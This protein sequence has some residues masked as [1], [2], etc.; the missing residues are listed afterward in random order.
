LRVTQAPFDVA[1]DGKGF[2]EVATPQGIRYTRQGSLHVAQDG[3]LVTTDG[4]PVLAAHPSGLSAPAPDASGRGPASTKFD[5]ASVASR[6]LNLKDRGANFSITSEG[7]IYAG[8]DLIGKLS[9]AEFQNPQL[10]RKVGGSLFEDLS[11][12]GAKGGRL[13]TSS[14]IVRQGVLEVSN[15][16]PI[17]EMTKLIQANRLFEMD[18]KAMKTYGDI[19]QKETTEVG[20]L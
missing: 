16:N 17:E 12:P 20:K 2:L 1:L 3:R 14:T 13:P 18:L 4:H 5:P 15:V 10:L 6:Y 9:V 8:E 11:P 19:L 7:E